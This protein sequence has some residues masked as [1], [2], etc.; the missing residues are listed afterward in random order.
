M[1]IQILEDQKASSK[2]SAKKAIPRH[3]VFKLQKIK[4]KEKMLKK[5]QKNN[6]D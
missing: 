5:G 3:I 6:K 1:S 2:I 4:D